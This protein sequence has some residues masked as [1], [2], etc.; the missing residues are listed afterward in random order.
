MAATAKERQ[1]RKRV[2]TVLDQL[3]FGCD[4]ERVAVHFLDGQVREGALLYNAIKRSGKL[5][6][7][8]EEFSIDFDTNQVKAIEILC[9]R[10]PE[11]IQAQEA[12][13]G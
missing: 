2:P 1:R 3:I 5:I 8:A 10:S 7:I 4:A 6:N 13:Q 11:D 12:G 9:R